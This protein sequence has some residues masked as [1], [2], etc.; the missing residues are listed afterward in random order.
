MINFDEELKKFQP[1]LDVNEAEDAIYNQD[2]TDITDVLREL[3]KEE[4]NKKK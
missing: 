3:L 2:L 1:S 4:K